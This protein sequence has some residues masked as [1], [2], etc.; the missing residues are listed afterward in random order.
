MRKWIDK[1]TPYLDSRRQRQ[2][3][4][5]K[6]AQEVIVRWAQP[7]VA[8]WVPRDGRHELG[9]TRLA[10]EPS[11]HGNLGRVDFRGGNQASVARMRSNAS[12]SC[13]KSSP[14]IN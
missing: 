1:Q 5:G 3:V 14:R 7:N 10:G 4:L 9:R 2:A 6:E 11:G 8:N 12:A 13:G